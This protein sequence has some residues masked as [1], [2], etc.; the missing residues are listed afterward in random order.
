MVC[1]I[2]FNSSCIAVDSIIK[3]IIFKKLISLFDFLISMKVKDKLWFEEEYSFFLKSL[4]FLFP[5]WLLLFFVLLRTHRP[6]CSLSWMIFLSRP[7]RR[8]VFPNF[9]KFELFNLFECLIMKLDYLYHI[10]FVPRSVIVAV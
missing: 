2:Q 4:L 8:K 5:N 6:L 1:W 3:K 9:R 10:E 7:L